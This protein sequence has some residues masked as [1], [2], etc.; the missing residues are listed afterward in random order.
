MNSVIFNDDIRLTVQKSFIYVDHD[1]TYIQINVYQDF[2]H[3]VI[4]AANFIDADRY[5][6]K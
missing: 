1:F 2:A 6:R 4:Y 5:Q 3:F